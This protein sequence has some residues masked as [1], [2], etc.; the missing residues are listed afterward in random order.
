MRPL[1]ILIA[2][3]VAGVLYLLVIERDRLMQLAGV[4]SDAPAAV[5][6]EETDAGETSVAE[7]ATTEEDARVVSVSAFK[8]RAQEIDNGVLLRGRTEAAR[9]VEVRAETAG[10]VNSEPL[11]K[12]AEV[13]AGQLMCEIDPGTR[14]A[15]LAE[16]E[17]RL[18]EAQARLPE[19]QARLPE[20]QGRLL[21][22]EARLAEARINDNA[23]RQLSEDGFASETRV[24][25]TTAAVQSALASVETAKAGVISAEAGL[26]AASAGIEA[27]EAAV[28]AAMKEIDRLTITAPFGGILETDTAELGS[29]LQPGALC[30]TIIQLN[31]MKLVGFVPETEVAKIQVG[32]LAGGRTTAGQEVAGRVTFLSR[33]SD[34]QTRTFRVEITVQ[35]DDFELRDG[36]TAEILI[37]A[38]GTTAHLLPAS[39]LTLNDTG[40]LGVRIA[41]DGEAM[42]VPVRVLRDTVE[43]IWVAGLADEADVIITGQEYVTDGVKI[44]VSLQEEGL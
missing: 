27:A 28:A 6:V 8:S 22:A 38:E 15:S 23:A 25:A 30:G 2:I 21:E 36:Q 39:A 5:S 16:A 11:R 43:G 40:A 20:A 37:S 12:G 44:D 14:L 24:A 3:I 33:S 9:K 29:L 19:A 1:S 10:L 41:E 32:A 18:P 26:K 7:T 35:N 4:Q 42:F 31:P 17:A 13:E 34:E